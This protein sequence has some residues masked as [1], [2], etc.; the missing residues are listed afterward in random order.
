MTEEEEDREMRAYLEKWTKR[1]IVDGGN[2]Q[3]KDGDGVPSLAGRDE[4]VAFAENPS[5]GEEDWQK[6]LVQPGGA[7]ILAA[8]EVTHTLSYQV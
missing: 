5:G 1:Y 7:K 2:V 8:R 3:L 4:K 6:V